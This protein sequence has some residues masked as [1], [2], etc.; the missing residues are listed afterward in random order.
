MIEFKITGDLIA[1]DAMPTS[2]SRRCM[3]WILH[4]VTIRRPGRFE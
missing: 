4:G 3:I 2:Y 1:E